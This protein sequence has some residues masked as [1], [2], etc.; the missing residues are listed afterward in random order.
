[1]AISEADLP[2]IIIER[3]EA[4]Y[5]APAIFSADEIVD[6]PEGV[7]S[8]LQTTGL[9]RSTERAENITC[10]GCHWGCMKPVVV[11]KQKAS[12][13][14]FIVCDE[15]PD[16]GRIKVSLEHLQQYLSTL[17]LLAGFLRVSLGLDARAPLSGPLPLLLGRVKGRYGDHSISLLLCDGKLALQIGSHS[18]SVIEFLIYRQGQLI[19]NKTLLRKL[20]DRKHN[21]K[22]KRPRYQPDRI[23]Q[24]RQASKTARR[25]RTICKE[26]CRIQRETGKTTSEISRLLAQQRRFCQTGTGKQPLLTAKRI[27]RIIYNQTDS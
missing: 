20:A 10:D 26:A 13:R 18:R 4:Y 17:S 15:E 21:T 7:I 14:A 2:N 24:E 25:D 16:L 6:W 22:Q 5:P 19:A 27:Y 1:M 23:K 3:L 12:T 9:I 8:E 11:R